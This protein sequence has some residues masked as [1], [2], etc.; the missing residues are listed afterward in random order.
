MP[1]NRTA[2]RVEL[3]G[4]SGFG[5]EWNI[6]RPP[7]ADKRAHG[8]QSSICRDR[9]LRMFHDLLVVVFATTA[10]FTASG[11]IANIYRLVVKTKAEKPLAKLSYWAVMVV[12]GPTVLFDN[13][14]R[15]WKTKSCSAMAFWLATAI[16]GYWSFALGLFVIQLA[17][18]I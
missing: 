18:A 5:P 13:A 11:I 10:G 14:A 17:L 16:C 9:G 4:S 15:S 1:G 7:A 12:A 3:G 2:R 8:V 6:C